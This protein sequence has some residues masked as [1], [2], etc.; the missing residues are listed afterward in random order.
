VIHEF[1]D[2]ALRDAA[3]LIQMQATFA[4]R[5]LGIGSR[6]KKGVKKYANSGQNGRYQSKKGFWVG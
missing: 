5:I 6:P 1:H 2:L 4:L 3:N